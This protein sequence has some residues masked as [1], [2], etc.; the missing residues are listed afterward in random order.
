M[1]KLTGFLID[2]RTGYFGKKVIENNYQSLNALVGCDGIE[3]HAVSVGNAKTLF[4]VT[5]GSTAL[6]QKNP[7]VTAMRDPNSEKLFVGPLFFTKFID[8]MSLLDSLDENLHPK[9]EDVAES[10]SEDE[11]EYLAVHVCAFCDGHTTWPCV[12]K[13]CIV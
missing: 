8:L 6:L 3:W 13:V 7:K 5:C 11:I 2:P 4:E 1:S 9:N 10:L 12:M